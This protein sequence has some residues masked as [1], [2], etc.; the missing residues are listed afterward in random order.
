MAGGGRRQ[1]PG[2]A[3]VLKRPGGPWANTYPQLGTIHYTGLGPC[4]WQPKAVA[5]QSLTPFVAI[6]VHYP[7]GDR[8]TQVVPP[9]RCLEGTEHACKLNV[10]R[11]A[12]EPLHPRTPACSPSSFTKVKRKSFFS[13]KSSLHQT[14]RTLSLGPSFQLRN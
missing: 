11:T 12:A 5:A 2:L 3:T 10:Q 6:W 8:H 9:P 1:A 14:P 4:P 7:G 13:P